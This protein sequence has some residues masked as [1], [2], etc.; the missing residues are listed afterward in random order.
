M[1]GEEQE[2][3]G[4]INSC[5]IQLLAPASSQPAQVSI[6]INMIFHFHFVQPSPAQPSSAQPSPASLVYGCFIEIGA[7]G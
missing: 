4:N 3:G 7:L 1:G 5:K 6:C 2:Q